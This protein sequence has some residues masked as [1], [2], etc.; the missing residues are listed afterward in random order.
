[1]WK[2][3]VVVA[4]VL[5]VGCGTG[6]EGGDASGTST[7]PASGGDGGGFPVP[8]LVAGT[9][10]A[11]VIARRMDTVTTTVGVYDDDGNPVLNPDG[12][13]QTVTVTTYTEVFRYVTNIP[14]SAT[15]VLIPD[16]ANYTIDV[17]AAGPAAIVGTGTSAH[18]ARRVLEHYRAEAVTVG[19]GSTFTFS[20]VTAP[21]TTFSPVYVGLAAPYDRFTVTAGLAFP[22]TGWTMACE[23]AAGTMAG[24]RAVFPAPAANGTIDCEARFSLPAS[25]AVTGEVDAWEWPVA[26]SV[27]P[28]PSTPVVLP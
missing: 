12:T 22:L 20:T 2:H 25:L 1:M 23:G 4:A 13:Q 26:L 9:D 28:T 16:G 6:S 5:A 7:P 8:H 19:P 11:K 3:L 27:T 21:A 15:S 10:A 18:S 24:S 17:V 14:A